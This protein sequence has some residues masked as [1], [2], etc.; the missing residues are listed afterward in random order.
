MANTT[1]PTS[2]YADLPIV[3][4]HLRS[5]AEMVGQKAMVKFLETTDHL[6]HMRNHGQFDSPLELL[7][8][9]WWGGLEVANDRYPYN[10]LGLEQNVQVEAG[11]ER[12]RLDF[13]ISLLAPDWHKALE[14]GV[15]VWPK[16]AVELDGH[17]FHERTPEQV[18]RRDSRDRNLQQA[19]WLVFHYSWSEFTKE[20]QR[21][22]DE[23]YDLATTTVVDLYRQ[24]STT[25]P[26]EY[27]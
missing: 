17:A 11:G 26:S 20:P 5:V 14:A 10:L 21:C 2:E 23:V 22:V 25:M 6:M 18:A 1:K 16:I 8:W 15:L 9:L 24:Y 27:R 4:A 12:Y 3:Q 13:V 7:F 19:G